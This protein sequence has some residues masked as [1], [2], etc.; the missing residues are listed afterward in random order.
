M[1]TVDFNYKQVERKLFIQFLFSKR[2]AR[3][4]YADFASY[5]EKYEKLSTSFRART[6]LTSSKLL[7]IELLI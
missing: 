5:L 2:I 1:K 4:A 6:I 7:H 3:I